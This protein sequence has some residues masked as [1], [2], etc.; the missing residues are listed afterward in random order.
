M[1]GEITVSG[2]TDDF[3]VSNELYTNNWDLSSKRAVAVATEMQKA[4]GF[5]KTR[6]VVVGHAETR[7]LVPNDSDADR[8]RNR[9]VEISIMQ[10]KAK[11]SDPID[12]R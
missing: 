12:V 6:M 11:E 5:D 9:R 8:R 4:Q 7:P 10:G 2:H 1:P 3:Q